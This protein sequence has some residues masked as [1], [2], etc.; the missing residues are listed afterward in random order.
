MAKIKTRKR[1]DLEV[2]DKRLA[3]IGLTPGLT[4]R[5]YDAT[6]EFEIESG[7]PA[8][9]DADLLRVVADVPEVPA[10][11]PQER[12]DRRAARRAS[13]VTLSAKQTWN[14]KDSETALRLL[15]EAEIERG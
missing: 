11:S 5:A 4:M 12:A 6:G 2:V 3:Q 10:N 8:I 7:D 14:A 9:G 1:V 13:A 15:L